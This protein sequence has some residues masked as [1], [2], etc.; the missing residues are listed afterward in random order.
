[1]SKATRIAKSFMV[2][3]SILDYLQQTRSNGSQ[4][5][6]VNALLRRAIVEEQSDTLARESS[7]FFAST[8]KAERAESKAFAAA[9]RRAIARDEE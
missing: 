3:R 9:S 5:E 7:E 8:S 2:D 6:R 4:S 1:M